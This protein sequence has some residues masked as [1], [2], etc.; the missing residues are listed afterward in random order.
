MKKSLLRTIVNMSK[1]SVFGILLQLVFFNLLMATDLNAQQVKSVKDVYVEVGFDNAPMHE[2]FSTLENLTNYRFFMHRN[3]I[4]KSLRFS[5]SRQSITVADV[6]LKISKDANLSFKQLNENISVRKV[7]PNEKNTQQ[8][9]IVIQTRNVSGKVTSQE[10]PEGLPGVNVIEKGTSNGTVTDVSGGYSLN[11][12][13]GA[14]LVFSSVG[15]SPTEVAIGN[16]SV[17]DVTMTTDIRQ[18]E[19][20]VVVGYGTQRLATVTGSISTIKGDALQKAPVM[21]YS[22]VFYGRLPGLVAVS[23]SGEPGNDGT[24][25]RI[26]GANTLGDNAPLIVVDGIVGRNLDR[27]NPEDIET[28]TV[29]KDASAAIY[30]A[31]AANGVILITTKR[32]EA[33]PLSV[34]VT[35][36]EGLGMPTV[37]PKMANSATYAQL[38]NEIDYY[39]GR[40]PRFSQS[41]IQAYTD[42]TDPWR[43]PDTDWFGE[44]FKSAANQRLTNVSLRGGTESLKYFVSLGYN[45]QDAIYKNSATNYSQ[46]SF[47]SNFDARL[48]T[49][50]NLS[51][52]LTGRQT[53]RNY[54]TRSAGSIFA[55]LMRGKPHLH[56]YWPNG[57]NGPDIEYG[58]N[59]VVI[60]T[61]QTGYNKQI[62][63]VL[64]NV[65]KLDVDVPWV[66]G[67]K[68]TS[69]FS[70]DKSMNNNK[71]W[72]TPWYLYTWDGV[73][74]NE[75]NEPDLVRGRRGYLTPQLRQEFADANR[76]TMNAFANYNTTFL[77]AH[78]LNLMVGSERITGESM[79]FWAFRRYF[80]SDAIDQMFAGGDAEKDNSGSAS[81]HARL[82]Y[83]GRFNYDYLGK[84]LFEFVFRYDGSFIFPAEGR[85]GFFPGISVGYRISEE[86]FWKNNLSFIDVLKLRTSW[87]QTGNDRIEPYQYLTS[88][89][90][91]SQTY[92]FG[93][94][95]ENKNLRELRTPNENVTWEVANQ[96]NVGFDGG[97]LGDRFSF[98]ADYFYNLRTNILWWRNASVPATSG[99]SL[100]R[101][102]IGKVSNKGVEF[103]LGYHNSIGDLNY[104]V[105]VTGGSNSNRIK[106]WD[107]TPGVPEYQKTTGH[108]MNSV[109]VYKAIGVFQNQ[110]E[111][112]AYPSWAG[113]RPGD[114]IF[115]DVNGDG[116]INGL[117]RVREYR[118]DLPTFTGGLSF[119]L[120]YRSF[121]GSLFF[122]G[123]TG[124]VRNNYYPMQGEVGNYLA[125]DAARRWTESNPSQ[126]HPR[127]WNRYEQYW[128]DNLNTYWLQSSDYLRLKN[129]QI[130]YDLPI[131]I[132]GIN[133][134]SVYFTGQNLLTFT[135]V[136]DFDPETTSATAY[137]LNKVYNF[138]ATIN[139]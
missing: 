70:F 94:S 73:S 84:Y 5:L 24:T 115:E 133:R 80:D 55:F 88:F 96:F 23:R 108:P 57:L 113:A 26:R 118:T 99:I 101:E 71:L 20:L 30:G 128:R 48:S 32:G 49:H 56:A 137:P 60:T 79:N 28:V 43:Y 124:A 131:K 37:I 62:N 27:L 47:R 83:F 130:G 110:E 14:V 114:I 93:G 10:D 122:Q 135:G 67:L 51:L 136:K 54:P 125:R 85:Y 78:N 132:T 12:S 72:Q 119:N 87:G 58:D 117:D 8:L 109:L 69:N 116:A 139:F 29:L 52:D 11:V 33:R 75:N 16:R 104:D 129:I 66:N 53:N 138:G 126:N 61:D 92:I 31:R 9:E 111:I 103:S 6:L 134:F 123:A 15:Y 25:L 102:N 63:Y 68:V 77:D 46:V 90:F 120:N 44:T 86:N 22:N 36:N 35:H 76:I 21:N 74:L 7:K 4:D 107:E 45:F 3:D 42:G 95:Q 89:G 19:E 91:R 18:L 106:F 2:V 41:D 65:I 40:E 34:T 38:I 82:N 59:P 81:Q 112:D 64:D 13:E 127:I 105:N 17:V 39:E 1:Y 97:L 121:Y 50:I 98:S 100:P